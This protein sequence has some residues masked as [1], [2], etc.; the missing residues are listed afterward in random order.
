MNTKHAG[1]I[2]EYYVLYR[3]V[4]EGFTAVLAPRNA[5][6]V[7]ILV[8]SKSGKPSSVQVK[9]K[10]NAKGWRLNKKAEN[11]EDPAL[12]YCLVDLGRDGEL[13][14]PEVYVV[15]SE[16]IA[17][18][19]RVGHAQWLTG[20]KRSGEPRKNSDIRQVLDPGNV[21]GYP[22]GWLQQYKEAWEQ[23]G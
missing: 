2:G 9:T 16:R 10:A 6:A 20:T 18:L 15:P 3:L 4:R 13:D 1:E 19:V 22:P 12:F 7:D 14:P 5:D 11:L 23:L 17:C 8:A 21:E